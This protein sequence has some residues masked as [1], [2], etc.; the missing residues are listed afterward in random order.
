MHRS[1]HGLQHDLPERGYE[2]WRIV[3]PSGHFK[4]R[5]AQPPRL[6]ARLVVNFSQRFYVVRNKSH[7]DYAHLANPLRGQ[8]M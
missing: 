4:L 7:R 8:R 2:F 6:G 3:E 5:K 1:A